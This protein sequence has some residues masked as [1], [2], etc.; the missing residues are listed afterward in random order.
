MCIIQEL[1]QYLSNLADQCKNSEPAMDMPVVL[2]LDNL[3]HVSSLAEIF[4]G[5]LNCKN[6]QW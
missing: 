4:N 1:K 6:H 2:I 3:H 5:L